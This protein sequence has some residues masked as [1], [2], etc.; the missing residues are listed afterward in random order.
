[1][2]GREDFLVPKIVEL[3][4]KYELKSICDYGCG[5]G[6]LLNKIKTVLPDLSNLTGVDYFNR[7]GDEYKFGEKTIG[8]E[9]IDKES[10]NFKEL[11]KQKNFDLIISTFALHH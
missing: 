7:F 11:S 1:M 10:E 8:I 5:N 9:F 2:A 3:I 6:T 4:K